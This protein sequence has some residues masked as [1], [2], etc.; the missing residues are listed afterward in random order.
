M[1]VQRRRRLIRIFAVV[2]DALAIWLPTDCPVKTLI[3]PRLKKSYRSK[4]SSSVVYSLCGLTAARWSLFRVCPVRKLSCCCLLWILFGITNTKFGKMELV[5]LLFFA[6]W[7][8]CCLWW[9]VP[10]VV[11]VSYVYS[12]SC[13]T[14]IYPAFANSVDLGLH[15][16]SLSMWICINNL[17]QVIWL[18]EK[19][20]WAW[21]FDLFSMT[22]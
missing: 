22:A 17:D 10:L 13:W 19:Q 1:G 15:C 4:V 9:F 16:L 5:A 3:R 11:I 21:H 7:H 14:Q 2:L 8:A 6:L 20:K 18:A 12:L